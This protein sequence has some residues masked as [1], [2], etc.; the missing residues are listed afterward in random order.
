[1]GT[2]KI[3]K[4]IYTVTCLVIITSVVICYAAKEKADDFFEQGKKIP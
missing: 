4:L 2:I 1:M 3:C